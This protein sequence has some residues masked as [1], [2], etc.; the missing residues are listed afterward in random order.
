MQGSHCR[1]SNSVLLKSPMLSAI[2]STLSTH[3]F[4]DKLA[5]KAQRKSGADRDFIINTFMLIESNQ[6]QEFLSF[7]TKDVDVFVSDYAD[8]VGQEKI[9]VLKD[10][11]D[12]FN[13]AFSEIKIPATSI[14]M[15]LYSGYHVKKGNKSFAKLVD[16]LWK[17]VVSYCI[18]YGKYY[19]TEGT[20]ISDNKNTRLDSKYSTFT[21]QGSDNGQNTKETIKK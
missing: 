19:Y 20:H 18:M 12:A 14:P 7:R 21:K 4:M 2:R 17:F 13:E 10:A 8:A 3:P 5:T 11:L 9:A 15:I 1:R 6:E 16:F